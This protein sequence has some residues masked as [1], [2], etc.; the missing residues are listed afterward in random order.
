MIFLLATELTPDSRIYLFQV[1][2]SRLYRLARVFENASGEALN[3][4]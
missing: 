3:L 4:H 2:T 1:S